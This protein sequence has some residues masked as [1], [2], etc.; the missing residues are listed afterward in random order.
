MQQAAGMSRQQA[1][2]GILG[3]KDYQS[4]NIHRGD[5]RRLTLRGGLDRFCSTVLMPTQASTIGHTTR[6]RQY[7]ALPFVADGK[8]YIG[9]E[10][11]DVAVFQ[12]G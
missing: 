4:Y 12:D 7:G 9:D 6:L 1:P 3:T 2:F 5:S 10:D 11:G 8:V